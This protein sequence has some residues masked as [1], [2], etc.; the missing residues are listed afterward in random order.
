MILASPPGGFNERGKRR[1]HHP[2]ETPHGLDAGRDVG[3]EVRGVEQ[4]A[5]LEN[6]GV[7]STRLDVTA[8]EVL[9][10][11]VPRRFA[12]PQEP[13]GERDVAG[14]EAEVVRGGGVSGGEGGECYQPAIQ[15]DQVRALDWA[16]IGTEGPGDG[17]RQLVRGRPVSGRR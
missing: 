7:L 3:K 17:A 12:R 5:R 9:V 6:G 8:H 11:V 16:G 14:G 4:A 15:Q 2:Q 10:A 13:A 1:L